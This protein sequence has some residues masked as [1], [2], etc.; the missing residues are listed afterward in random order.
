MNN[1]SVH[2]N[3]QVLLLTPSQP[4]VLTRGYITNTQTQQC[5]N[6]GKTQAILPWFFHYFVSTII[7]SSECVVIWSIQWFERVVWCISGA[8]LFMGPTSQPSG[9]KGCYCS[10]YQWEIQRNT[11]IKKKT[12]KHSL[13]L[14]FWWQ[15]AKGEYKKTQLKDKQDTSSY[16]YS[17]VLSRRRYQIQTRQ[18][19]SREYFVFLAILSGN[20][21]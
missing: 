2:Y 18:Y 20:N 14:L 11:L 16:S 9:G 3:D 13:P 1:L 21:I 12:K 7:S 10:S 17:N 4:P 6:V 15:L 8:F 5:E 19:L